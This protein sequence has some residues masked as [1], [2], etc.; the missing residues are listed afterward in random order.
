[1]THT[2]NRRPVE[3]AGRVEAAAST[4]TTITDPTGVIRA[5]NAQPYQLLPALS[6]VEYAALRDDVATNGIRVPVD[7]DERGRVLDGHHRQ[8]IAAESGH[9]LSDPDGGRN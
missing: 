3:G 9:R 2:R 6:D 1:M 4:N 7:V 5:R 8:A